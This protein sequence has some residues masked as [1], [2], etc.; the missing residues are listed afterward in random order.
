MNLFN[1][2]F[3]D[4]D[5]LNVNIDEVNLFNVNFEDIDVLMNPVMHV[6]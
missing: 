6:K 4:I 5:V 3:K 1:V 2:N